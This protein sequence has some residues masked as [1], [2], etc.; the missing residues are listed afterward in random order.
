MIIKSSPRRVIALSL[1]SLLA[2]FALVQT[3]SAALSSAS[4][5]QTLA[6]IEREGDIPLPVALS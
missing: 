5:D 3:A 2:G 4:D 1:A 6:G